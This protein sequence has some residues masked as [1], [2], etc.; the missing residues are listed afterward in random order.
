MSTD[1][2]P[3]NL[4]N[5][6]GE[7]E[8]WLA[9]LERRAKHLTMAAK[10]IRTNLENPFVCREAAARLTRELAVPDSLEVPA[11]C[12]RNWEENCQVFKATFWDRLGRACAA[13]GWEV[14][15]VTARRLICRGIFVEQQENEVRLE[16]ESKRL[17][18]VVEDLMK[19]LEVLSATLVPRNFAP[20]S[21][22]RLLADACSAVPGEGARSLEQVYR[23][24]VSIGQKPSFWKYGLSEDFEPLSRMAFRARLS[25]V[26]DGPLEGLDMRLQ[27][28]TT[29]NKAQAW[30]VYSPGEGRVVQVGKLA[31][32]AASKGR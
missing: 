1:L 5:E 20:E 23:A 17:T 4:P 31:V 26:L 8:T 12:Q 32:L 24:C 15:G 16:G 21:F 25:A 9:S 7:R 3:P 6:D 28:E 18:P 27:L 11:R 10:T 29:I 22:L 14:Y 30:E 13:R 2:T 19:R